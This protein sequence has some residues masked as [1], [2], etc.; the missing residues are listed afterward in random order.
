MAWGPCARGDWAALEAT[1]EAAL[2]AAL[3]VVAVVL[4]QLMTPHH[5]QSQESHP[6]QEHQVPHR[7]SLSWVK[8]SAET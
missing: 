2:E 8:E 4:L 6:N 7:S 5:P 1:L 3:E